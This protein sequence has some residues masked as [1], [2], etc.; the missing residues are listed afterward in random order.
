MLVNVMGTRKYFIALIFLWVRPNSCLPNH[1]P[2]NLLFGR[3]HTFI[4]IELQINI[5]QM[6]QY[7]T[8]MVEMCFPCDTVDIKV[9]YKY[10]KNYYNH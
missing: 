2:Q 8:D 10:L 1:M 5:P 6:L 7:H 3:E 4:G 9:I